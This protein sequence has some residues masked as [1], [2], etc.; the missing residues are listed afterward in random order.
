MREDPVRYEECKKR[1]AKDERKRLTKIKA[2]TAR[3]ELYK[4]K[5]N[6]NARKR[7]SRRKR[8]TRKETPLRGNCG[9]C[10]PCKGFSSVSWSKDYDHQFEEDPKED[11]PIRD[12]CY[13]SDGSES[14]VDSDLVAELEQMLAQPSD[15][16][17]DE[18]DSTDD[19]MAIRLEQERTHHRQGV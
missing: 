15:E 11:V 12:D 13:L 5:R 9:L 6:E 3:Y 8:E 2:D 18:S 19:E 4:K 10:I 17:L 7:W 1:M 14:S 16:S